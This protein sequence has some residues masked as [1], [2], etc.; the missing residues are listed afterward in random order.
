MAQGPGV[1][2]PRVLVFFAVSPH[3]DTVCPG[4]VVCCFTGQA[5]RALLRDIMHHPR[6]GK[7]TMSNYRMQMPAQYTSIGDDERVLLCGG[8]T[9]AWQTFQ[10]IGRVLN[11]VARIFSAGSSIVNNVVTIVRP[12]PSAVKSRASFS[13]GIWSF[14]VLSA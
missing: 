7:D 3:S 1:E 13:P 8:E 11:Y 6:K 14:R 2:T 12:W 5:D 4:R 10:D 9:T